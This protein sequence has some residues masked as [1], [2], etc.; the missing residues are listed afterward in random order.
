MAFETY[1]Y[2][3]AT[4][5]QA[6]KVDL[7]RLSEEVSSSGSITIALDHCYSSNDNVYVV[8]K[9]PLV[10][11]EKL[12]LDILV[13]AHS[14]EPLVDP[15]P[16]THVAGVAE[17]DGLR[18]RIVG[19][20]NQ[21]VT[22]GQTTPIDWL[23]PQLDWLGSPKDAYFNGIE[24]YI[25]GGAA[26]DSCDFEVIDTTGAGV[27]HGLYDQATYDYVSGLMGY[28]PVEDFGDVYG[29]FPN[30]P[31][32]ILLYKAHLY[33]GLTIRIKF[34]SAG[35]TDPHVMMNLYRHLDGNS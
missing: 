13:D 26:G 28:M 18:A 20:V 16:P 6:Q 10:P 32:E 15:T 14:G 23:I 4:E 34:H 11:A 3:I 2:I 5:I 9:A 1:S 27:G 12:A 17:G 24:Y 21:T 31:R 35:N 19:I 8:M 33:A 30:C 22:A 29:M 7:D 25:S